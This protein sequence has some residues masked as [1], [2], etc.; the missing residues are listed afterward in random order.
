MNIGN[1]V[2]VIEDEAGKIAPALVLDVRDGLVDVVKFADRAVTFLDGI[3][4]V[5]SE[6]EARQEGAGEHATHVAFP[7]TPAAAPV[8][9]DPQTPAAAPVV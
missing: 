4:L 6:V 3:K 9:L 1:L 7:A 2:H 5:A 8:E